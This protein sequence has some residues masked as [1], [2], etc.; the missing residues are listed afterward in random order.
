[1]ISEVKPDRQKAASLLE[2]AVITRNRLNE[3]DRLRYPSNTLDD[4][5]GIIHQLMEA[6]AL[7]DGVKAR[8]E[9]AHAELID[10]VCRHHGFDGTEQ[11]FLQQ[12]REYRN[13]ISYEGFPVQPDYIERNEK[14]MEGIV[15][16][17]RKLVEKKL[18]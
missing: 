13:R 14:R 4:Y 6:L 17:L 2:M 8:G 7:L 16:R 12:L 1:M 15:A 10:Y 5:Y 9:G 3:T 11:V 18:G